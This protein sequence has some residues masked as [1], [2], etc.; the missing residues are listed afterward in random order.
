MST[1]I[2]PHLISFKLCP[3][4][5]RSV[6]TLLH[7]QV[8]F[9]ITYIDLKNKPDW[10]LAISPLGKVPA[11]QVGETTLFES[12]VINEYLDEVYGEG[13]LHPAD[14]LTKALNRAWIEFG[15]AV[16]MS[17]YGLYMAKDAETFEAKRQEIVKQIQQLE[18]VIQGPFFNGEDFSLIDASYAPIWMRLALLEDFGPLDLYHDAPKVAAWAEA[19]LALPA[20][21]QSVVPEFR[22]LSKAFMADNY[23]AQRA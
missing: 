15:S 3:F 10:F 1:A 19:T 13:S 21:Q 8:P 23:I 5:Q 9:E 11:L 16:L 7:K 20:V 17:Q 6:I 18:A 14:P 22:E 2:K 4:V 12:A